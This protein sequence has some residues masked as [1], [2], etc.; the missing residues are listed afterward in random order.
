MSERQAAA[1][2]LELA[3]TAMGEEEALRFLDGHRISVLGSK[4]RVRRSAS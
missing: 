1:P 4:R 3:H 2:V